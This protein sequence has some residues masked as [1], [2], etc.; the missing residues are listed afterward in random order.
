RF[1][2]EITDYYIDINTPV[3]D[4]IVL[5]PVTITLSGL[6]GDYFYS[7]NKIED[8]IALI[9]TSLKLIEEFM[10]R[11]YPITQQI[12]QKWNDYINETPQPLKIDYTGFKD[13]STLLEGKASKQFPKINMNTFDVF[14]LFQELYKLKSAQ[15]RAFFFFEALWKARIPFSVETTWKR[16]DNMVI[17]SITPKRDN[18]ADITEFSITVK[19]INVTQS[20]IETP[21]QFA[22]RYD[23]QIADPVDKGET[24]GETISS[25]GGVQFA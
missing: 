9:P 1:E 13:S 23:Q 17:Q 2:S 6:V 5:K 4:H 15:T 12:K 3:Q 8:F 10:N 19:Q 22:N 21:S 7:V 24:Q 18:N 25:L 16:Y 14:S 20:R 11:E